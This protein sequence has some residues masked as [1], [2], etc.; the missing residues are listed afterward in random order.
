M[1][2][3]ERAILFVDGNNWYHGLKEAGVKDQMGLDWVRIAKKLVGP[4]Q[5]IGT[6]YYVG[7]VEQQ[8]N[9]RLYANQRLFHETFARANSSHTMHYGRLESQPVES[10]AARELL[11]YLGQLKVRLDQTVYQDLVELGKRHRRTQVRVEKAVDVM[12][13]VD[14]VTMACN[15]AYD[16]A[17]LLSADGDYTHA[18]EFVKQRGLKVFAVSASPGAQLARVVNNFIRVDLPWFNGLYR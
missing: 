10:E 18:A 11:E 14:M 13:A 12:V 9:A 8:G 1:G 16:T 2:T 15:N 17:Y 4:R 3:T 7:R 5:W 6:R